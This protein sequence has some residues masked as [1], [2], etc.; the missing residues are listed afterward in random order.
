MSVSGF[1]LENS[2]FEL[3]VSV[4]VRFGPPGIW[5]DRFV[6][7]MV[8][9]TATEIWECWQRIPHCIYADSPLISISCPYGRQPWKELIGRVSSWPYP[10]AT[11]Y[12]MFPSFHLYPWSFGKLVRLRTTSSGAA[13]ASCCHAWPSE[14]LCPFISAVEWKELIQW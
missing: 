14:A 13:S 8:S 12:V 4:S 7:S 1:I 6:P 5:S 10:Y 3:S 2:E 9:M 11:T